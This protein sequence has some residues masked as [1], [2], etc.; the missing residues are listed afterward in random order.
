MNSK[1][2]PGTLPLFWCPSL[3]QRELNVR[4]FPGIASHLGP[5]E[6]N[7]GCEL[8]QCV[9]AGFRAKP[10]WVWPVDEKEGGGYE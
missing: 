2:P 3:W 7:H 10:D 8:Y 9:A 4:V 6:E 5:H 1:I